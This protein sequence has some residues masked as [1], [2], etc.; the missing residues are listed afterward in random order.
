MKKEKVFIKSAKPYKQAQN[1]F[2]DDLVTNAFFVIETYRYDT[3]KTIKEKFDVLERN[4]HD[5]N[6]ICVNGIT[7]AIKFSNG[8][9]VV[10]ST[11]EWGFVAK[12]GS[13]ND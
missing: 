6:K 10:F 5:H 9:L 3:R 7:V 8:K 12:A 13:E 11:S 2:G 1:I 4:I